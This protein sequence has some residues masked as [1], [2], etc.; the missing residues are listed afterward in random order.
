MADEELSPIQPPMQLERHPNEEYGN[1]EYWRDPWLYGPAIERSGVLPL[2]ID[3]REDA[4]AYVNRLYPGSFP[5]STPEAPPTV[6]PTVV[7]KP[8]C[9]QIGGKLT[10]T[11]GNWNNASDATYKYEWRKNHNIVGTDSNEY[12][13]V[14]ADVGARCNC[15]VIVTNAVGS[16]A[17]ISDDVIVVAF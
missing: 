16:A 13:L 3:K 10:C 15:S 2:Y 8:H 14:P 17:D 7:D 1:W 4:E 12:G 9:Q 6:P 5:E 11:M